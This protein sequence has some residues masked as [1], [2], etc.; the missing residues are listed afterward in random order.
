[1]AVRNVRLKQE[2]TAQAALLRTSRARLVSAQEQERR[3][4]ERNIHDGVQQDLTALIGLVG[5]ARQEYDRGADVVA[6]DLERTQE[7]LRRVLADLRDF[8]QGIHPSVLS[9][10]GLLAAVEALAG[11]HPVPVDVRADPA[12]RGMHL[13]DDVEGAAYFTIAEALAN[14]LKHG[15]AHRIEIELH[16]EQGSLAVCARDDGCGFDVE[17][18]AGRGLANLGERV[19]AVGGRLDVGSRPGLGTTVTAEFPI[20]PEVRP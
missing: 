6:E 14:T 1:M 15:S 9:D 12:L 20:T 13:P 17:R 7:G 5:H 11:R 4:I 8:A 10:R 2:L 16:I 18:A 3:R 19:A